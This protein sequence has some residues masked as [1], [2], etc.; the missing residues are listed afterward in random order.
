VVTHVRVDE[1]DP[2]FGDPTKPIGPFYS[3]AQAERLEQERGWRIVSDA[4]R[5]YRRVVPSPRPLEIVELQPTET[6]LG[7]GAPA[8]ACGGRRGARHLAGGARRRPRGPR[9]DPRHALS[10]RSRACRASSP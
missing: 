2:A 5:G 3:Q 1:D 6:L 7:A 10:A 9:R 4:G 8:I